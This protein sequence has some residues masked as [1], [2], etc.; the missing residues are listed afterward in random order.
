MRVAHERDD[1]AGIE[2]A[3]A[4]E[5]DAAWVRRRQTEQ[6]LEAINRAIVR[7]NANHQLEL[8]LPADWPA[9]LS[10]LVERGLLPSREA[11]AVDGWGDAFRESPPG[12]MP[13]VRVVSVNLRSP[14]ARGN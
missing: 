5:P 6:R 1:R 9:L 2:N 8:P 4:L 12:S 3:R 13:V 11:Y 7:Y 14:G 10:I